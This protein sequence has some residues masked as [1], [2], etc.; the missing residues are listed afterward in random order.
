VPAVLQNRESTK[1]SLQGLG[2]RVAR[3]FPDR[4]T[5]RL[6][7]RLKVLCGAH[8]LVFIAVGGELSS[9][10]ENHSGK[11]GEATPVC[12]EEYIEESESYPSK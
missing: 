8:A 1:V 12:G 10:R 2:D 6:P 11:L 5:S 7:L 9:E 3:F 4:K